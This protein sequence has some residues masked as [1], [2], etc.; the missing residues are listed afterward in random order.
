[1]EEEP[2]KRGT[3]I[4]TVAHDRAPEFPQVDTN[5]MLLARLEADQESCTAPI[6]TDHL[7]V[8]A[9]TFGPASKFRRIAR[10]QAPH[11]VG[12]VIG[13]EQPSR[14]GTGVGAAAARST[15]AR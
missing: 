15:T 10:M 3:A 2:P 9:R 7:P 12:T 13:F 1:M 11:L 8:R 5:L 6:A 4:D 14:D